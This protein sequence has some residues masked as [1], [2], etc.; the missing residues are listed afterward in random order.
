MF[1][2]CTVFI[3]KAKQ[4]L[5]QHNSQFGRWQRWLDLNQRIKESKSFA[6]PLGDIST[7]ASSFRGAN[8]VLV[9]RLP[10][11]LRNGRSRH[12]ALSQPLSTDNVG[13]SIYRAKGVCQLLWS[14]ITDS[15]RQYHLGRVRCYHYTNAASTL[16]LNANRLLL[17]SELRLSI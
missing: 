6:L 12:R 3:L 10:N 1:S 8:N 4:E 13:T 11:C 7:Y 17:T 2:R 15:N 14:S 9:R 16:T 5:K